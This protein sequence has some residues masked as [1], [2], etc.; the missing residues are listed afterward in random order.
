VPVTDLKIKNGDLV[1]ATQGRA[2]WSLDDITPLEQPADA[3]VLLFRPRD[4]YRE[5][6]G[7]RGGQSGM[8]ISY[9]LKEKPSAPVS[10]EITDPRGRIVTTRS[11]I[12]ANAGVNRFTWDMR[13]PDAHGIQGGTLLAGGNLRGPLA[14]PGTYRVTLRVGDQT[15]T[16]AAQIRKTPRS[17]SPQEDIESQFDFLL[18]VRDRLSEI[19]DTINTVRSA[20]KEISDSVARAKG[21]TNGNALVAAG[22]KLSLDLDSVLHELYEPR[23]TGQDD[24]MLIFP[25]KLNNRFAGLQGYV[26]GSDAAPTAQAFAVYD[27]LKKE[28]EGKLARLKALRENDA[29]SFNRLLQS[30]GLPAIRW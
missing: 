2:F 4:A 13:F 20:Q 21:I 24:Q 16:E 6:G 9:F 23:Y 5:S 10:I 25:L 28:L 15:F 3:T 30:R 11:N 26:S 29:A 22:E 19:H 17:D 7:G 8:A 27:E 18:G 14:V 12:S 1:V